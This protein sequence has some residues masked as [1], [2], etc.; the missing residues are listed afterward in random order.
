MKVDLSMT[1]PKCDGTGAVLDPRAIGKQM[2]ELREEKGVSLR[3]VAS[4]LEFTPA[5]ISD[6]EH[7]RR[8]WSDELLERYKATLKNP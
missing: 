8:G 2:R 7:G 1:C 6:L 5:Y 4:K 3:T